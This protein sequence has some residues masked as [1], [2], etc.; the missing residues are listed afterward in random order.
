MS[1]D[2]LVKKSAALVHQFFMLPAIQSEEAS[3]QE[4][5]RGKNVKLKGDI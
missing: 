1:D 4:L 5:R 3:D 2:K